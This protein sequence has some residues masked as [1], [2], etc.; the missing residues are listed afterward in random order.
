MSKEIQQFENASC[1][2][3]NA[4]G[5]NGDLLKC[6]LEK[7]H[8]RKSNRIPRPAPYMGDRE[9][10]A[11]MVE[12]NLRQEWSCPGDT[13]FAFHCKA[14]KHEVLLTFKQFNYGRPWR[15]AANKLCTFWEKRGTFHHFRGALMTIIK[16]TNLQKR[17]NSKLGGGG[18]FG[19]VSKGLW[20]LHVLERLC[21][22]LPSFPGKYRP[23]NIR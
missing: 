22:I 21:G 17:I 19:K 6:G 11:R 1:L 23:Q 10:S 7:L 3:Y 9:Q 14:T 15:S 4:V 8:E 20:L 12:W 2:E 13:M 5:D 18:F 16:P